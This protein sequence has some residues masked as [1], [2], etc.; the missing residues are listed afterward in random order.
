MNSR[1]R[2]WQ[3]EAPRAESVMSAGFHVPTSTA[4]VPYVGLRPFEESESDRFFGRERDADLLCDKILSGRLTLFYAQSGLGKSSLL[5]AVVIPRLEREADGSRV[6]YFDAWAHDDPLTLLKDLL[7]ATAS[8]AGIPNARGG[9]PSLTELARML[10][11][12]DGRGLTLVLDQFEEFLVHH[13]QS[14]DPLRSEL[15]ALLRATKLDATVVLSLREEFL[16][17]LEPLRHQI[18]NL[19]QSTYRLESLEEAG[20]RQAIEGP[21]ERFGKG[22]EKELTDQLVKY[23]RSQSVELPVLQLV[24]QELWNRS[25]HERLTLALYERLGGAQ[26]ILDDYVRSLMPK[27]WRE[28]TFTAKLLLHLAPPSGLKV[29]YAAEDLATITGHPQ[30]LIENELERLARARILRTRQYRKAVRYELQHD[31]YIPVLQDWLTHVNERDRR[32]H[33][34]KRAILASVSAG[35]LTALI[36]G[37]G[38]YRQREQ[39]RFVLD[40]QKQT[41]QFAL[42]Q[43][44][45]RTQFEL[46]QQKQ[47]A[48]FALDGE[49]Q[50]AQFDLA[51]KVM[52][53]QVASKESE[54]QLAEAARKHEEGLRLQS[55]ALRTELENWQ[56][57][58][59]LD[60]LEKLQQN[61]RGALAPGRFE[62]VAYY[63][64][65]RRNEED[66]FEKLRSLLIRDAK[67][68]PPNFDAPSSVG[69]KDQ[70]NEQ[71][72]LRIEYSDARSLD[73]EGFQEMW[74]EIR[75]YAV[76]TWSLPLPAQI[77]LKKTKDL[78]PD[79]FRVVGQDV[80]PLSMTI[81]SYDGLYMIKGTPSML[82]KGPARDFIERYDS[83]WKHF[84]PRADIDYRLVPAWSLPVWKLAGQTAWSGSGGVI[85]YLSALELLEKPEPLF[86]STAVDVLL[87]RAA[88]SFPN[89]VAEAR[90]A[91]AASGRK[92]GAEL[93]ARFRLNRDCLMGLPEILDQF[94]E[95]SGA[96]AQGT[97][98]RP[99]EEPLSKSQTK[100][101][102]PVPSQA[103]GNHLNGPWHSQTPAAANHSAASSEIDAGH[104]AFWDVDSQMGEFLPIRVFVAQN[105]I[106]EWFPGARL[107]P[108]MLEALDGLKREIDA[109]YGIS[110]PGF[111]FRP[112]DENEYLPPNTIRIDVSRRNPEPA[113]SRRRRV[114][115]GPDRIASLV[116]ELKAT[117]IAT[118]QFWLTAEGM[119][120]VL[121]SLPPHTREM[122][123]NRYSLTDM[124][125]LMRSALGSAGGADGNVHF[126]AWLISSLAFWSQAENSP[127]GSGLGG[128]LLEMSLLSKN[129][130]APK[131]PPEVIRLVGQ[132]ADALFSDDPAG[133]ERSFK[134]AIQLNRAAA[135]QAFDHAWPQRLPRVFLR[136]FGAKHPVFTTLFPLTSDQRELRDLE[137]IIKISTANGDRDAQ[138]QATLFGLASK[139]ISE[140]GWASGTLG[141]LLTHAADSERSPEASRWLAM[142]FLSGYRPLDSAT[143][144]ENSL[145]AA[146]ALFK[147]S[148]RRLDSNSALSEFA[149]LAYIA[150]TSTTPNWAWKLLDDVAS[151]KQGNAVDA[152]SLEM[153]W[154][155]SGEERSDRLLRALALV[156][157]YEK[158]SSATTVLAKENIEFV[159]AMARDGL[160]RS[161]ATPDGPIEPLFSDLRNS[162]SDAIKQPA[163]LRTVQFLKENGRYDEAQTL[164]RSASEKWP[165]NSEFL[166]EAL[167]IHLRRNRASDVAGTV[168]LAEEKAASLAK[169]GS[170]ASGWLYVGALAALMAQTQ[171]RQECVDRFIASGHNY[172]DYLRIIN[173]AY[174]KVDLRERWKEIKPSTW[175]VRIENGDASAWRE[176]LIGRFVGASE[177]DWVAAEL[178][179]PSWQTSRLRNLPQSRL[180]LQCEFWFYEAMAEKARGN[181]ERSL[182]CLR[183][184]IATGNRSYIENSLAM[185]LLAQADGSKSNI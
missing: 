6:I 125:R 101:G 63:V 71:W 44:K 104:R 102:S 40:R 34:T 82:P 53:F 51:K 136:D 48:Q 17:A 139:P 1:A 143:G 112:Q 22:C 70:T 180:G 181:R 36:A 169:A 108:K 83:D 72:P 77:Y 19:F 81:P 183:K 52:D 60:D 184:C 152:I 161:G 96:I 124:K 151:M 115:D 45:Q 126:P 160:L 155:L 59:L 134:A 58:G 42:D 106:P 27:R 167:M 164:N 24:C 178:N 32:L 18:L 75:D 172:A 130:A 28:Q 37:F 88:K 7:I 13:G 185:F 5:R 23:L 41:A 31:A 46:D 9:S 145:N 74:R 182:E 149:E 132:G 56:T 14:L 157:D 68:L 171:D 119:D 135:I 147:S 64:L 105:L 95:S 35:L 43:Q 29:S 67:F 3:R 62:V 26:R 16:A 141:F 146:A 166:N 137:E 122:L 163:Y 174:A 89:T 121:R 117:L 154:R 97:A 50:R 156:K 98:E 33:W 123:E 114:L 127:D 131:V 15:A 86:S 109:A 138:W 90:A 85:G 10:C 103:N 30:L 61:D 79:Q 118:R 100:A 93:A 87:D 110:S 116:G 73:N 129:D 168:P 84:S 57:G 177:A 8:A 165:D 142:K 66:R 140:Q 78:A 120:A 150:Q 2:H 111:R 92:L 54:R 107:S 128:R 11:S 133:A 144:D 12:V 175:R 38:A 25:G 4:P 69:Q 91:S 179:G 39:A 21:A 94:A 158:T 80:A 47:K 159:R 55:E 99:S 170:D 162:K 176:I 65:W 173:A 153:A 113:V 148:I 49:R 76:S 20:L